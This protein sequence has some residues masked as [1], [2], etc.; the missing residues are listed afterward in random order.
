[1]QSSSM[2]QI[3]DKHLH[4]YGHNCEVEVVPFFYN[5]W[6]ISVIML[7]SFPEAIPNLKNLASGIA[8]NPSPIQNMWVKPSG[9][10]TDVVGLHISLSTTV[11]A[12]LYMF[13]KL[14]PL[15]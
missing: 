3:T 6:C 13:Y 2:E 9:N 15:L 8:Y 5:D 1:M 12:S 4:I 11:M 10:D 14:D 7:I